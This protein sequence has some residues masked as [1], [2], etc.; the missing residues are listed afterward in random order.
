MKKGE[1]VNCMICNQPY[2]LE[3]DINPGCTHCCRNCTKL[4]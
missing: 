1:I 3:Q 2:Q 4:E